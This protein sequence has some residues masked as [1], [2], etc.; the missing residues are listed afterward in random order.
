MRDPGRDAVLQK[1]QEQYLELQGDVPSEGRCAVVTAG[2]PGVG[3]STAVAPFAESYRLIDSDLIKDALLQ[4]AVSDGIY[5]PLL[6][7]QLADNGPVLPRELSSLVHAESTRVADDVLRVCVQRRENVVVEG[8]LTWQPRGAELIDIFE[9]RDYAKLDIVSCEA[10]MTEVVRRAKE[11]WWAGRRD[12]SDNGLGG[13]FV[14]QFVIEDLYK[15]TDRSTARDNAREMFEL[16]KANFQEVTLCTVD[17][18][19]TEVTTHQSE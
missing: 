15:V 14:P 18:H 12:R 13:R 5:E 2:P 4:L 6:G 3:K 1:V 16:A 9:S 8:T 11:R 7:L 17:P 19:G 10:P